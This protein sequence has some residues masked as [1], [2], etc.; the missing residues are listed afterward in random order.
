[1]FCNLT[2][3]CL[4]QQVITVILLQHHCERRYYRYQCCYLF[5]FA[6]RRDFTTAIKRDDNSF[7]VAGF[8][9]NAHKKYTIVDASTLSTISF[10][11]V[12]PSTTLA[13]VGGCCFRFKGHEFYAAAESRFGAFKVF[14]ISA[15]VDD[16]YLI[17]DVTTALGSTANVTCVTPLCV[18]LC[19]SDNEAWIY[20]LAPNNG[21]AAYK[22]SITNSPAQTLPVQNITSTGA[23]LT[24]APPLEQ[25]FS[26]K[27]VLSTKN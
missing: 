10:G 6:Q 5:R 24:V 16:A 13:S 25:V 8:S 9:T 15:G 21:I 14:D 26:T 12:G 18:E 23:P 20:V 22:L 7:F 19:D 2:Q 4:L 3:V 17:G 11:S 1:M 27:S